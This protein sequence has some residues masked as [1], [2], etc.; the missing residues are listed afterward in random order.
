MDLA[1]LREYT[2]G[3]DVRY[4]DW[5]VTA[6]TDTPHVRQ[7]NEDRE[8]TAWFLLD[9]SP[10]VDFGSTNAD[11]RDVLVG[12]VG[13]LTR[14]L[15]RHGN[16]VGAI[17]YGG[18]VERVIPP[19]GGR[20]HVLYI[21]NTLLNAPRLDSSPPTS[22]SDLL[23]TAAKVIRRRS[24]V[25]LISD[26]YSE[27]GWERHLGNLAQRHEILAV[28]VFDPL[29]MELP[30]LGM[31]LMSDRESGEQILVDTHNRGFRR[32]F[33]EAAE[34]H[35]AA[36]RRGL[37]KAGVDGLEISTRDDLLESIVKYAALR[38]QMAGRR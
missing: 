36:L 30:D 23:S 18:E 5:N 24:L 1:D 4:I 27:P 31:L 6:R 11:K 25:F 9:L 33:A 26:F 12:F 13:L 34:A 3:D 35:E 32:R 38:K 16:R 10:S 7:Y 28:R 19:Q 20:N 2:P 8:I 29:E 17:F 21:L 22:L 14:L 37:A 15:T